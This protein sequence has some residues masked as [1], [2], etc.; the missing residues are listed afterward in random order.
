MGLR[1]WRIRRGPVGQTARYVGNAWKKL[2]E[3]NPAMKT[4]DIA[5]RIANE[6]F[7]AARVPDIVDKVLRLLP[8]DVDPV[9]LSW[10]IFEVTNEK[11]LEALYTYKGYWIRIMKEEIRKCGVEP[12]DSFCDEEDE[13]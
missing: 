3:T 11:Q 7:G 5:E 10:R 1:D 13:G 2:S 4:H 9:T 12:G 6:I 8:Y